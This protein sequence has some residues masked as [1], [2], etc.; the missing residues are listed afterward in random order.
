MT[1]QTFTLQRSDFFQQGLEII[2]F[3]APPCFTPSSLVTVKALNG[4]LSVP[5]LGVNCFLEAT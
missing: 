2:V 1:I 5:C 4:F 3:S